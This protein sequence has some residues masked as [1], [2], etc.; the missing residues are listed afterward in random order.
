M[1][2]AL[3][4]NSLSLLISLYSPSGL[5]NLKDI[6]S[7]LETQWDGE[8]RTQNMQYNYKKH[9]HCTTNGNM[10]YSKQNS[11]MHFVPIRMTSSLPHYCFDEFTTYRVLY[12][13]HAYQDATTEV[14]VVYY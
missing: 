13:L 3:L 9:E 14:S 2:L 6:A 4:D 7:T 5:G 1:V 8:L 10:M 12:A 11:Q